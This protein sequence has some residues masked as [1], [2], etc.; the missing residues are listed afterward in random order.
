MRVWQDRHSGQGDMSLHHATQA[1]VQ[2]KTMNIC[3]WDFPFNIFGLW[4]AQ[5]IEI[6]KSET[7]DKRALL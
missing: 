2:F 5:I 6:M 3:S 7:V 4:L 1:S